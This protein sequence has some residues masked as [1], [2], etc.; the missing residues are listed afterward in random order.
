MCVVFLYVSVE[1]A[2]AAFTQ[3]RSPGIYKGEYL[4]ELFRRY[5]DVED[6]PPPPTLPEWCFEDDDEEVDDDGNSVAQASEPS[7]SHSSHSKKKKERLKLARIMSDLLFL[8]II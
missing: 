1:A 4:K 8:Q 5:G 6:A 7:S 3:A 2:V